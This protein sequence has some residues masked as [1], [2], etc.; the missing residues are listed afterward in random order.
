MP[1]WVPSTD[2]EFPFAVWA[3][4]GRGAGHRPPRATRVKAGYLRRYSKA[5]AVG[6]GVVGQD[7]KVKSAAGLPRGSQPDREY[8]CHL[9]AGRWGPPC[10]TGEAQF[11]VLGKPL[12]DGRDIVS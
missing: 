4:Q 11:P 2:G 7:G 12:S 8:C 1:V 6:V 9:C 3:K 5:L 10:L